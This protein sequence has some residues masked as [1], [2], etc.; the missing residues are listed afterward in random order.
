[1]RYCS[2]CG[3]A[4]SVGA[5]FCHSC[6]ASLKTLVPEADETPVAVPAAEPVV[7]TVSEEPA[8][9]MEEPIAEEP[10]PAPAAEDPAPTV[11]PVNC[12]QDV[13]AEKA[14]LDQTHRLLRWERK[15][16]SIAG[17]VYLI[18][19]IVYAALFF[20]MGVLALAM[21]EG[22][23][24]GMAIGSVMIFLYCIVFGGLFIAIG[25][26]NIITAGKMPQYTDTLYK[27]FRAAHKRCNS[28]GMIIFG[29]FFNTI[30]LVFYVINFVRMKCNKALC[31]RIL[32]RQGFPN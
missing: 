30:A 18:M 15:A 16:W 28:I 3:N 11:T 26:I 32:A 9:V 31:K 8:P 7:E 13:R 4:L 5:S 19:G 23:E 27:D 22:D 2:R 21:S 10:T 24:V 29:Y 17:K 20:L 14:F 12:D 1:M 6:G 25:V